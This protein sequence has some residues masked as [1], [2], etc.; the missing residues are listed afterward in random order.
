MPTLHLIEGPVGAGKST[1]AA[2]L[3][4]SLAAPRLILDEWMVTL[5]RPDRPQTDFMNWYAE[6]KNRCIEQ[7]WR[8]ASDL[9]DTGNDAILELGLVQLQD[10]ID[11]Y[12]RID[13]SNADLKVY[14]IDAPVETRRQRVRERNRQQGTTFQMEVPDEIFEIANRAWQAPDDAE[15][16]QRDIQLVSAQTGTFS[17]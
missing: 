3:G 6:R 1:F 8:V 9:L 16:A 13:A 14:L 7:I 10:R 15:L 12:S 4:A 11:F 2:R 17:T 5:F